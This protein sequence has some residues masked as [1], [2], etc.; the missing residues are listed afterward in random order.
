[1]ISKY[2]TA[3]EGLY[4]ERSLTDVIKMLSCLMVAIHHYSGYAISTGYDNNIILRAFST[5]GGYFG[6]ALFFFLSGYGLMKSDQKTHLGAK[7]FFIKRMGKVFLPVLLITTIWLPYYWCVMG[8][9]NFESFNQIVN[10]IWWMGDD[11]MWFVKTLAVQYVLFYFYTLARVRFPR[12]RVPI[13]IVLCV[14][15]FLIS[16]RVELRH[17]ISLPLFYSGVFI[18]D[19]GRESKK[20]LTT[21]W[22]PI[23]LYCIMLGICYWGRHDM[24]TFHIMFNYIFIL[25]ILVFFAYFRIAM[26]KIPSWIGGTSFDVYLVHNKVLMSLRYFLGAVPLWAF[27]VVTL[28]AT[29]IFYGLRKHLKI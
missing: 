3:E 11:V 24:M 28:I 5:Q 12:H 26:P 13:L 29:I 8:G 17:A 1:M 16:Y 10:D 2:K 20:Y 19:Y 6:V 23:V 9:G 27:A 7:A 15:A 4:I 25:P 22:F 18:A 21:L 14:C